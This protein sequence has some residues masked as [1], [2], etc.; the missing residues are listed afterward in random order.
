[1]GIFTKKTPQ[2]KKDFRL[3]QIV[4]S[5]LEREI[6]DKKKEQIVNKEKRIKCTQ[7]NYII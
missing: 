2:Q 1:M 4:G 6:E 5:L 7:I 3:H